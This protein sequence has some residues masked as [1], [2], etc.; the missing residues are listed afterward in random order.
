MRGYRLFSKRVVCLAVKRHWRGQDVRAGWGIH[1]RGGG[2]GWDLQWDLAGGQPLK[3]TS[4]TG[5]S[6]FMK[7]FYISP[8]VSIIFKNWVFYKAWFEFFIVWPFAVFH[9]I[10]VVFYKQCDFYVFQIFMKDKQCF[11]QMW[12][13]VQQNTEKNTLILCVVS[14]SKQ[15]APGP[16]NR[17]WSS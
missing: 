8:G 4:I 5:I 12:S 14:I 7:F 17:F 10:Q 11:C 3:I 2:W 9:K 1:G 6:N 13:P 16:W 15:W